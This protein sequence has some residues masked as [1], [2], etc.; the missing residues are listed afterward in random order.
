MLYRLISF[1]SIYIASFTSLPI[2]VYV[3]IRVAIR[4]IDRV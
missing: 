2:R 4:V 1:L 3:R